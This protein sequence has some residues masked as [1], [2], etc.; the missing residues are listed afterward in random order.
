MNILRASRVGSPQG[1]NNIV[2]KPYAVVSEM[3]KR[4]AAAIPMYPESVSA[5]WLC[6]AFGLSSYSLQSRLTVIQDR[7]LVAEDGGRLTRLGRDYV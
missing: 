2:R 4:I 6:S 1:P 5:A 7:Y 3:N